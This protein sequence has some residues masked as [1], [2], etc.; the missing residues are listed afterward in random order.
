MTDAGNC[1]KR[2]QVCYY[3]EEFV[4]I[5]FAGTEQKTPDDCIECREPAF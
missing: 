3:V 1:V 2:E 5:V 4:S